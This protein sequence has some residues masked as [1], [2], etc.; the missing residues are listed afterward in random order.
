MYVHVHVC[1]MLKNEMMNAFMYVCNIVAPYI[2]GGIFVGLCT[3]G[4]E[5]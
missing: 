4:P 1:I 5:D 2:Y 3:C